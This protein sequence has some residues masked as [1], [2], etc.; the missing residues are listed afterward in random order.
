MMQLEWKYA[1]YLRGTYSHE[2]G[3][4][5]PNCAKTQQLTMYPSPFDSK[6]HALWSHDGSKASQTQWNTTVILLITFH[7]GSSV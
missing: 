3:T 1:L 6:I 2:I 4:R 7:F 5:P